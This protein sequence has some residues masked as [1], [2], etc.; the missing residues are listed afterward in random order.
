[1]ALKKFE[2]PNLGG[3]NLAAKQAQARIDRLQAPMIISM[4]E[5]ENVSQFCILIDAYFLAAI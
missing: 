5:V 4:Y 2:M 3:D 1:V